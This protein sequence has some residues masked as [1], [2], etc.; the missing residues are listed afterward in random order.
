MQAASASPPVSAVATPSPAPAPPSFLWLPRHNRLIA[1][2]LSLG[3]NGLGQIYNGDTERGLSMMAG[4]LSYPL[5]YAIDTLTQTSYLRV[6]SF[7][8]N[9]GVKGWSVWDAYQGAGPALVPQ[10]PTPLAT[11]A[12]R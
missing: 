8:L 10:Q 12:P 6:F 2:S 3:F 4:W 5:A 11:S 9:A 1:V 7:T